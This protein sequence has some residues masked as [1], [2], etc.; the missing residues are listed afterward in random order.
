MNQQNLFLSKTVRRNPPSDSR[1]LIKSRSFFTS[2]PTQ[3]QSKYK[4]LNICINSNSINNSINEKKPV[5]RITSVSQNLYTKQT[6][7]EDSQLQKQDIEIRRSHFSYQMVI[8]K[9]GFG[10][11]WIVEHRASKKYYA[12]KEMSKAKIIS[13]RSVHSVLNERALLTVHSHLFIVNMKYAFQDRDNLYLVMDLLTGGDLRF[14]ICFHRKFTEEQTRFFCA[15]IIQGLEYC[16]KNSILHRDIKPENQVFE[17]TGYQRITDFGIARK[18]NP[19]NAKE[20]SGTP[21]YMAPEVMCR[22]NHNIEVDYFALGVICYECMLGKRPY[23]GRS[24]KEIRDQIQA[25]QV[26]IKIEDIPKGWSIEAADF[27]N[28]L[29]QRKPAKRLGTNGPSEIKAHPWQKN[30]PFDKQN[31]KEIEPP[32]KPNTRNVFDY[33][34]HLSEEDTE[35][36]EQIQSGIVQRRKSVQEMFDGY[37]HDGGYSNNQLIHNNR[38]R[39]EQ[40][41]SS[42]TVQKKKTTKV[43]SLNSSSQMMGHPG[44][45]RERQSE[46]ERVLEK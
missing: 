27:I 11:V 18:W 13:K 33:A 24:R 31:R 26:Q 6:D 44:S 2:K 46:R 30:Y 22:Q 3:S 45:E 1:N 16:H 35:T 34:K 17:E 14:H 32:F 10:K 36:D 25:K 28:R 37:F 9:G 40:K 41:P 5:F 4:G 29:I 39:A 15:C 20:T 43:K 8:G 21:G 7:T 19:D 12:L 42:R 23:L 38:I